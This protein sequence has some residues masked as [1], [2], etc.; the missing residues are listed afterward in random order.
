MTTL[1]IVLFDLTIGAI[2]GGLAVLIIE[3]FR[4]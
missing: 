1:R 4:R 3:Y 2:I